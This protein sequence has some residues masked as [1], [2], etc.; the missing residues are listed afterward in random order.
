[1]VN[2]E[3]KLLK[4]LKNFYGGV[5]DFFKG[6]SVFANEKRKANKLFNSFSKEQQA[7]KLTE[8]DQTFNA[9]R[10]TSI[11]KDYI[12]EIA[13]QKTLNLTPVYGRIPKILENLRA[14]PVIGSFTAYPAERI[15]NTY[16]IFKIATDELKE[17]FETGNKQL[18]TQGISR[19]AQWS[20]AQGALYTG[21]YALNE[22]NGFGDVVDGM[23]NFLPD[24]E[25]NGA[26]VVTGKDKDGNYKYVDLTY[27]HPDSQFQNAIVPI[28]LK[29]ARGEDVS[30][31]LDESVV[32]SF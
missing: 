31:D 3:Q 20:A 5:D 7:A 21:A 17:G 8:F 13:A 14:F 22:S 2:Q 32:N 23:R 9:G 10:G 30:K 12:K 28:I 16:Q 18:T 1:M 4:L 15:R 11:A 6:A 26:L 24:W 19:L 25:K 27:I 29:A